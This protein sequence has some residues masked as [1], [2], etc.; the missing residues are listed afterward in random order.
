MAQPISCDSIYR[1]LLTEAFESVNGM[2][3]HTV[4]VSDLVMTAVRYRC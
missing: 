1:I 3:G 2:D 4:R